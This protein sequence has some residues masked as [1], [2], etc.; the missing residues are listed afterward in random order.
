M[1]DVAAISAMKSAQAVQRAQVRMLHGQS[2]QLKAV[3]SILLQGL[4]EAARAPEQT[5]QRIN[6]AA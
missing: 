6:V 5:G 3:M 4:G 1:D 2:E